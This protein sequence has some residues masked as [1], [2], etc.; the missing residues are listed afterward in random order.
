MAFCFMYG[1]DGKHM[2]LAENSPQAISQL[3]TAKPPQEVQWSCLF[4]DGEE[5]RPLD[6]AALDS[7][8]PDYNPLLLF[9]KG[10]LFFLDTYTHA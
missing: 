2:H 1:S 5:G 3:H 7:W 8:F 9:Y 4:N 10:G 6:Q